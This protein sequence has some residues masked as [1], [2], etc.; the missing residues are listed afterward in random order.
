MTDEL[1]AALRRIPRFRAVAPNEIHVERL[2]GLTNQNWKIDWNGE[3]FVLRIAGPGTGDYIDRSNESVNARAA[4]E[5]KVGADVIF[6]DE[7]SGLMMTRFI[8]GAVTM[9]PALFKSRQ[10]APARAAVALKRMHE[11]G[12]RFAKRFELFAMI[13]SYRALLE[14]LGAGLPDGYA[15][16]LEQAGAVR[17][18]LKAAPGELAPCHCDPLS[19]NFLDDGQRM[20]V[21]DWEYSGMNDPFWDL[22]D[23]AVEADF[24]AAQERELLAA[25]CGG[26]P[27]AEAVGRTVIYK[28]MCDLLWTLW[29]LIQHANQNPVDDFWA[30]A[31]NRF[32]RC[33]ALMADPSFPRHLA[34]IRAG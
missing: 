7:A 34:A 19:E 15:A 16:A 8:P 24:D 22:G 26:P 20:W 14:K 5:A 12:L 25:Y 11:S 9:S 10:G 27:S 6:A 3:A 33:K 21:V 30:Y 29:G 13:D 17:E 23:L 32:A 4:S 28:A 18:A 31:L 1:I 2:G